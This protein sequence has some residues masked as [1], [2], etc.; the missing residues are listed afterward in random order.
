[1]KTKANT[2]NAACFLAA[3]FPCVRSGKHQPIPHS[4]LSPPLTFRRKYD[5]NESNQPIRQRR[6][7]PMRTKK[8][9]TLALLLCLLLPAVCACA[10]S[11]GGKDA[12]TPAE[13]PGNADPSAADP[14]E[15]A[16]PYAYARE[17]YD[18]IAPADYEGADFTIPA[19]AAT[20]NSEKEIWVEELT[21]DVV[22]DAVFNRNMS[23][24]DR[25]N[26]NIALTAGDVNSI[27]RQAVTSGDG[28]YKI[29]FPNMATAASLAQQG[30]LLDYMKLDGL[31]LTDAWWDQGTLAMQIEGRVF[32]MNGDINYLDNDVTYIQLFNKKLIADVGLDVPYDLVREGK[33][34]IDNFLHLLL[35]LR[36]DP[37]E[38]RRRREADHRRG[39]GQDGGRPR[40]SGADRLGGQ[41]HPD[42][43]QRGDR[44]SDVHGGPRAV[45]RRS[46]QLHRERPRHG[47]GV[48]RPAHSEV[49][50]DAGEVLH[51][52]QRHRLHRLR[53]EKHRGY[54]D[55]LL[56]ARGHGDPVLHP[57]HPGLLRH[58]P[59][60]EVRPGQRV[61]RNA[62]YR[63]GV[64]GLRHRP[65]LLPARDREH[66]PG[67]G[68]E[69]IHRF[70]LL[71]RQA[72]KSRQQDAG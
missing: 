32:F 58:R 50:R 45:L 68:R 40:K 64:P 59:D 31:N 30:F 16:D 25:F 38:L 26:C 22:N 41:H 23:V 52:L 66:F 21:G 70:R 12:D 3:T 51:L 54:R 39:H 13:T 5:I 37:R 42:P 34:T 67:A 9:L 57:G 48:R 7:K 29:A 69:G 56:R 62:G 35:R 65:V 53:P 2:V 1:M 60:A 63:P 28:A 46:P 43:L 8:I 72:R 6:I 49:R 10:D 33:W 47:D 19:Q 27:V 61:L 15:D 36:P 17:K 71:L 24:N 11:S 20:G 55:D 44:Q 14:E 18:A 4:S